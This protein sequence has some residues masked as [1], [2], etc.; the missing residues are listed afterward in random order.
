[1]L[2]QEVQPYRGGEEGHDLVREGTHR[3]ARILTHVELMDM[4]MGK[5]SVLHR[6]RIARMGSLTTTI[7]CAV[8]FLVQFVDKNTLWS[9]KSVFLFVSG[10]FL[11][12]ELGAVDPTG[13][14]AP[15]ILRLCPIVA[16]VARK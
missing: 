4:S 6:S 11:V 12:P 5:A 8:Q 1:M 15:P 14:S 10:P 7:V 16:D 13:H 9:D 2:V 3:S